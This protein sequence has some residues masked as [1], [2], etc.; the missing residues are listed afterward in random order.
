MFFG[1]RLPPEVLAA[2]EDLYSQDLVGAKF[3]IGQ[4]VCVDISHRIPGFDPF[5][6]VVGAVNLAD[7]SYEY[8]I[9]GFNLMLLWESELSEDTRSTEAVQ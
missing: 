2:Y 6:G 9:K 1:A 7:G 3:K 8:T 4:T 5:Y